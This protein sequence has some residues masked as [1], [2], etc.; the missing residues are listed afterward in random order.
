MKDFPPF[1]DLP[2]AATLLGPEQVETWRRSEPLAGGC[3]FHALAFGDAR[4]LLIGS[5][6]TAPGPTFEIGSKPEDAKA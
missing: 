2:L 3:L 6:T 5:E 4:A 1:V